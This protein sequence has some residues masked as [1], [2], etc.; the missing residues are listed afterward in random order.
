MCTSNQSLHYFSNE[1]ALWLLFVLGFAHSQTRIN[2]F[3]LLTSDCL[4][5]L[6]YITNDVKIMPKSLSH[7]VCTITNGG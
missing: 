4:T 6:L 1:H 2:K 3:C 7:K 5:H